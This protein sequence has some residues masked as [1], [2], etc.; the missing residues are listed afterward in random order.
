MYAC[1]CVCVPALGLQVLAT[2]LGFSYLNSGPYTCKW[3]LCQWSYL[4]S[5]Q[6]DSPN[7]CF[8]VFTMYTWSSCR[9]STQ[10]QSSS[11]FTLCCSFLNCWTFLP[12]W[13]ILLTW[14]LWLLLLWAPSASLFCT[15]PLSAEVPTWF[16]TPQFYSMLTYALCIYDHIPPMVGAKNS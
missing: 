2:M 15:R 9:M 7:G 3:T 10:V 12:L 1:V 4:Y 5:F 6:M 16:L 11:S 8:L 13:H 14:L